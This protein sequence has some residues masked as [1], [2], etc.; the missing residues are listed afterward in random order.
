M[1]QSFKSHTRGRISYANIVSTLALVMAT[2]GVAWAAIGSAGIKNNSLKSIDIKNGTLQSTDYGTN[3]VNTTD[4]AN[5]AI[6]STKLASGTV[7]NIMWARVHSDGTVED[8]SGS[9]SASRFATGQYEVV[10]PVSVV[11]CAAVASVGSSDE[12]SASALIDD[13]GSSVLIDGQE[14]F[15]VTADDWGTNMDL[16]FNIMVAC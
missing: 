8:S 10:F 6:T 11:N 13:E 16:E 3:S 15:V 2:S 14:V 7:P 1:F 9:V 4:V 12:A 5:G